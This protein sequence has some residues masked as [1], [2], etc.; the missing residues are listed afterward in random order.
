METTSAAP[1]RPGAI[2]LYLV[3]F[4]SGFAALLYQILWQRALFSIYGTNVESVT[5]VVTAFMLGLG[6]GSL[7]GGWLS[8]Q[9]RWPLPV[10]FAFAEIGIG[11]FGLFSLALFEMVGAWTLNWSLPAVG[12]ITLLLVFVPTLLMG[13]TLPLLV[14]HFVRVTGNVGRSVGGLYF[15]NTFGSAVGSLAAVLFI[16][17]ALGMT[18]AVRFAAVL[19][20][21]IGLSVFVVTFR[22]R[23][24]R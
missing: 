23:K 20:L 16:L 4:L 1:P 5:V 3:F 24:P 17:G 8:R 7:A 12:G 18:G 19:N 2:H 15:I 9:S 13:G 14:A 22:G 11:L 21:L 6:I 10:L